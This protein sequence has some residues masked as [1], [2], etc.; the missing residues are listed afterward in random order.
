MAFKD[1]EEA[2]AGFQKM[3]N[4]DELNDG[5]RKVLEAAGYDVWRNEVG[6]T[7]IAPRG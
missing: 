4:S 6:D 1:M 7:S 5:A 3:A 2:L